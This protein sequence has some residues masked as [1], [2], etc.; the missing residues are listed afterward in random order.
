MPS[1]KQVENNFIMPAEWEKHSATWL[2]W[3]YDETTFPKRVAIVEEKYCEIIKV[4]TET[5]KIELLVLDE[6]T[7]N[8]VKDIFS[9]LR[10][11][12]SQV[13]FHVSNYAD[14]WIRDYGPVF[15]YGIDNSLAWIKAEYNAYGKATDPFYADLLKDNDVFNSITPI[16]E[17]FN[18]KMVLEGGSIEVDGQGNLITTE[19][20]LLNSN[21]NPN[22]TKEQIEKNLKKYFGVKKIIWLK[23][24]LT[25]D[26]T[27][28][29]VDDITRFVAPGK[30]LTCYEDDTLDENYEILKENYEILSKLSF[31]IIKLPMPHMNYDDGTKAPVSYANFYISNKVVLVPTF[32]DANDKRAFEI[33]KSCFPDHKIIGTDCRDIIYGG[34]ALHCI[35][36]QQPF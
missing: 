16:G 35:T 18:L 19:Q 27:D 10:I 33:I 36:Q 3:P 25:N 30:I 22:L 7:K 5:E 15:L 6:K 11:D 17:K 32:N 29:H 14:V 26:H 2:A 34:G 21:R 13:N 31:E 24:G 23:R 8:R 12:L 20:C 9:N 28:G 4:L 1:S